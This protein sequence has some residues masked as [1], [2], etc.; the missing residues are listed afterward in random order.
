MKNNH[1]LLFWTISGLLLLLFANTGIA[2]ADNYYLSGDLYSLCGDGNLELCPGTPSTPP[3]AI[4][5]KSVT[6]FKT[7]DALDID[8]QLDEGVWSKAECQ[9]FSN[10]LYSDNSTRVCALWDN[11]YLFFSYD[12]T[13]ANVEAATMADDGDGIWNDDAAE[14]YLD[15][16]NNDGDSLSADDYHFILNAAGFLGD[17]R[18]FDISYD[19][20][21]FQSVTVS[22]PGGYLAEIKISWSDLG[23]A[24]PA[25]AKT[26]GLLLANIDRDLG[27]ARSFDWSNLISTGNYAQPK[28]WGDLFISQTAVAGDVSP[29]CGDGACN[30]SETCSTCPADCGA[31]PSTEQSPYPGP[32]P[33]SLPGTIEAENFDNGGEGIAYHDSD[34]IHNGDPSFRGEYYVDIEACGEGGYDVGYIQPGEWLEYTVNIPKN[35]MY[36]LEFRVASPQG[37]GTFHLEIDDTDVTGPLTAPVT[38][39]WQAYTTVKK[40][41]VS[42]S[43][44]TKILRIVFDTGGLNLNNFKVTEVITADLVAFYTFDSPENPEI[45]LSGNNNTLLLKNGAAYNNKGRISGCLL[46]DGSDDYA[47]ADNSTSL[48]ITGSKITL[49][50]WV[51][52]DVIDNVPEIIIGKPYNATSHTVPYFSYS[53]HRIG[54][55]FRMFITIGNTNKYASGGSIKA[56]TWYHVAGTYDGSAVKL[57]INGKLVN[58]YAASGSITGYNTPLLLGINGG[59]GE[60]LDGKLDNIYIFKSALT[61]KQIKDIMALR[62][63]VNFDESSISL[64]FKLLPTIS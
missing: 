46:L 1:K 53:L 60:P 2:R 48:N 19:A 5:Y 58:S 59:K 34:T 30:G 57:Y 12:V 61:Q 39:D 25:D 28:Y 52:F 29:S 55:Y 4:E 36:D 21:N 26:M 49:A 27:T 37:E 18:A 9:T 32:N 44:G 41:G 35:A 23:L 31:C 15:T 47:Q 6:A 10:S 54:S 24:A 33:A 16:S 14:L 62:C 7:S 51:R 8:G 20:G 40:T 63:D 3:P 56:N 50:A 38:G 43:A 45:D 22:R 11:N 42:L 64:M 17:W 13:D